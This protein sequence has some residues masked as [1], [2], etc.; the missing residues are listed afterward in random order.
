[1]VFR[2]IAFRSAI[3]SRFHNALRSHNEPRLGLLCALSSRGAQVAS[4]EA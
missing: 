4:P 3:A 1:M 2:V